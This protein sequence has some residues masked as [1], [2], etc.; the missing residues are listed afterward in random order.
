MKKPPSIKIN[1]VL[2]VIKQCCNILFPLITYPYISRVLGSTNLGKYSFADSIIQYFMILATLGVTGYAVREGARIR[3]DKER[4][5]IFAS[6]VLAINFVSL[7]ISYVVLV[8]CAFNIPQLAESRLLLLI[9]SANVIF[10]VIG[11]D[12]V[13]LIYEDVLFITVRYIVFQIIAVLLLFVFVRNTND[14][15]IYTL[16]MVFAT[17]GAQI[18]NIIRTKKYIPYKLLFSKNARKHIKPIMLM[19]CISAASVVYINSDVTILGL[20]RSDSE[21]GIYYMAGKIYT[22]C[23]TL[24]NAIIIVITP[25]VAYYLGLGK[26]V[27]Y[28]EML[29]S[30]RKGLLTLVIPC[31]VG[32]FMMSDNVIVL[33]ASKEFISGSMSLRILCVAMLFAV[34]GCYYSQGVLIPNRCEKGFLIATI[35]SAFVNIILNFVLIPIY[36]I[37]GAAIATVIAEIIVYIICFG[38][39]LKYFRHS[40]DEEIIPIVC[41]SVGI[42]GVC[43]LVKTLFNGLLLET[44][45]AIIA[46]IMVYF[47]IQVLLKNDF[48]T[49]IMKDIKKVRK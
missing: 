31:V 12:W 20:L 48:L 18:I 25:R 7:I 29:N 47:L 8:L 35:V 30:L 5:F 40:I 15:V 39:S 32:L 10:T 41:G 13:N 3:E 38:Y 43:F 9:L 22:L 26:V 27:E 14:Y 45:V 49:I 16:I 44:S 24:M 6:E 33:I 37:N 2:N 17:S 34:L 36:G 19:L 23:K 4:I 42:I 21:V 46:S 11:R 1:I 28:K